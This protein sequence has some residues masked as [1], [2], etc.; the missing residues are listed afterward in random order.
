M[1]IF[2]ISIGVILGLALVNPFDASI[3]PFLC[4]L[5]DLSYGTLIGMLMGPS[6]SNYMGSY[7]EAFLVF[8]LYFYLFRL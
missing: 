8:P 2:G 7:L 1:T 4:Y 6:L 3:V 5:D